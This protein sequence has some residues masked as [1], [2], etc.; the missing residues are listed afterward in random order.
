MYD[1]AVV[2]HD[3]DLLFEG[4]GFNLRLFGKIKLDYLVNGDKKG[5]HYNCAKYYIAC[6]LSISIIIRVDLDIF[7][8]QLSQLH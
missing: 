7:Y 3:I 1:W 5:K 4:H 8:D 6:Q 2:A